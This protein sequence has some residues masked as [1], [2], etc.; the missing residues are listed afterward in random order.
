MRGFK[1]SEQP[2]LANGKVRFVG[3]P[4]A[5][6]VAASRAEAED[7]VDVVRLDFEELPPVH[8]M[9]AA[10]RPDST[11]VHEEFLKMARNCAK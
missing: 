2:V 8:E 5:M 1:I 4:V 9:L 6:C 10:R 7:L 3:E 11:R